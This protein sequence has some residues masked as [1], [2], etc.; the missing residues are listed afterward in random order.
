MVRL[1]Y[2]FHWY[3]F[4]KNG[5]N[6]W[7]INL[8]LKF[9]FQALDIHENLSLFCHVIRYDLILHLRT[10][11]YAFQKFNKT[12]KPCVS[13]KEN[14]PLVN[15]TTK[16]KNVPQAQAKKIENLWGIWQR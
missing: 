15:N 6:I 8:L 3:W 5:E 16:P 1:K 9:K 7:K 2:S 11:V 14:F 13:Q 4:A 12:I 10:C